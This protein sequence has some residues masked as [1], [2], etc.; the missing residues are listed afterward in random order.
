M[1]KETSLEI[2]R[3]VANITREHLGI[4]PARAITPADTFEDDLGADSLDRVE[5]A[6]AFEEEFDI[7]IP[8]KEAEKLLT[9]GDAI[10]YIEKRMGNTPIE[11]KI[12]ASNHSA[13]CADP[14]NY[15]TTGSDCEIV[16]VTGFGGDCGGSAGGE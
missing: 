2:T 14:G 7:E 8:D 1:H 15:H 9:V 11:K 3:R 16:S 12:A 4:A 6:M 5:L 10:G 13:A